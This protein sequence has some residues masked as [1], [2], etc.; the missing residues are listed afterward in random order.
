MNSYEKWR[1]KYYNN[2]IVELKKYINK[3]DMEILKKLDIL[4]EDKIYTLYEYD[5]IVYELLLYYEDETDDDSHFKKSL[6]DKH[7]D[8]KDY[9]ELSKKVVEISNLFNYNDIQKR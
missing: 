3:R 8:K 9:V 7:V 1:Y 6:E 2:K 5:M 4:I